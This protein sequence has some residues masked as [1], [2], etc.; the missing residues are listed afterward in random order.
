MFVTCGGPVVVV[1]VDVVLVAVLVGVGLVGVGLV[2]VGLVGGVLVVLVLVGAVTTSLKPGALMVVVK[3][4]EQVSRVPPLFPVP[5]HCV[6]VTGVAKLTLDAEATVQTA[7]E[8][9][10]FTEP[11]HWVTVA[12]SVLAGNGLQLRGPLA[13]YLPPPPPVPTHWLDVAADTGVASTVSEL[14]SFVITTLH[15][16]FGG[17]ASLAESLHWVTLVTR[18]VDV[19][20]NGPVSPGHTPGVHTRVTVVVEPL[21]A[22]STQL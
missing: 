3:L 18:L 9:P 11:L 16:T 19:L 20:T 12:G 14:M 6:T 8:P 15:V 5:L 13:P 1:L 10:P 21:L 7:V 2:G 17:A 4:A 22:P